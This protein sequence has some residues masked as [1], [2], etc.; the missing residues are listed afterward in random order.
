MIQLVLAFIILEV[1]G[2]IISTNWLSHIKDDLMVLGFNRNNNILGSGDNKNSQPKSN[3]K[4]VGEDLINGNTASD[5]KLASNGGVLS[6]QSGKEPS[7]LG[8]IA[9]GLFKGGAMAIGGVGMAA[10]EVAAKGA[11]IANKKLGITRRITGFAK[12]LISGA[13]YRVVKAA[14]AVKERIGE[15]ANHAKNFISNAIPEDKKRKIKGVATNIMKSGQKAKDTIQSAAKHVHDWG[16]EKKE[17]IQEGLEE[18]HDFGARTKAAVVD[19]AETAYLYGLE[20]GD[21]V[22]A[23]MGYGVAVHGLETIRSIANSVKS[24]RGEDYQITGVSSSSLV[25]NYTAPKEQ[26]EKMVEFFA[27]KTNQMHY[28]IDRSL[29]EMLEILREREREKEKVKINEFGENISKTMQEIFT[30]PNNETYKKINTQVKKMLEEIVPQAIMA[31]MPK[32]SL[33]NTRKDNLTESSQSGQSGEATVEN[34]IHYA[35]SHQA[36]IKPAE[37]GTNNII[38]NMKDESK[39]TTI[40]NP[41]INRQA[42]TVVVSNQTQE[43]QTSKSKQSS[44]SVQSSQ[45]SIQPRSNETSDINYTENSNLTEEPIVTPDTKAPKTRRATTAQK[46][47]LRMVNDMDPGTRSNN[48]IETTPDTFRP[49][50]SD[51][52]VIKTTPDTFRSGGKGKNIKNAG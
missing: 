8:K 29:T 3:N 47:E 11:S 16:A 35:E 10:A 4:I 26:Y 49:G 13:R 34:R 18:L 52:K 22:K 27:T 40:E 44:K 2:F 33:I 9:G 28:Y 38:T 7:R 51:E 1:G 50:N 25:S 14:S 48:V 31:A 41:D 12:P 30:D 21:M 5:E 17:F 32:M 23:T 19:K 46:R 45:S 37:N 24:T 36:N 43:P 42:S 20:A 39:T 6:K 15:Q